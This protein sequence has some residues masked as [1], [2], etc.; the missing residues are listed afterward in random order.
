MLRNIK[1]YLASHENID[2]YAVI[3]LLIFFTVFIAM[4]IYVFKI[5]REKID[6]IKNIPLN[7]KDETP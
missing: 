3:S 6:E 2:W 4:L 7:E 1:V 5:P